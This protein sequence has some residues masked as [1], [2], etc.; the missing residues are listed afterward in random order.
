[1]FFKTLQKRKKTSVPESRFNKVAGL[2]K[3]TPVQIFSSIFCKNFK[4][5]YFIKHL[6][7]SAFAFW[8]SNNQNQGKKIVHYKNIFLDTTKIYIY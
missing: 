3:E 5:T 6:Q 1:M 4:N 8:S 2:Q 7:A